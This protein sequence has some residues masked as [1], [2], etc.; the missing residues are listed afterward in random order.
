MPL[1][2]IRGIL[3]RAFDMGKGVAGN[4]FVIK[5]VGA[6]AEEGAKLNR[7]FDAPA[8]VAVRVI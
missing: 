1:V 4:F 7:L 3:D 5:A 6:A 2:P 8:E